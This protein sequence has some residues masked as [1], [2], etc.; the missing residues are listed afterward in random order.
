MNKDLRARLK[1]HERAEALQRRIRREIN[2]R[3]VKGGKSAGS[4]GVRDPTKF[5]ISTKL[6][7]RAV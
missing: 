2:L 7:Y 4:L 3:R 5:R 1:G 6:L